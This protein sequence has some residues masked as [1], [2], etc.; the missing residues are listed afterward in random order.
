MRRRALKLLFSSSP[1]RPFIP[2]TSN[3]FSVKEELKR[4]KQNKQ[5][6]ASCN[7]R[8]TTRGLSRQPPT[9]VFALLALTAVG[10][11]QE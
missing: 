5:T 3:Y 10:G 2:Q 9:G 1:L 8:Q 11:C 6:P 4:K 7:L